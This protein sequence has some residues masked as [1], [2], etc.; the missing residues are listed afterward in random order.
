MTHMH[1]LD[2]NYVFINGTVSI[3]TVIG[4]GGGAIRVRLLS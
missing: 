2:K 3:T 4:V 1:F